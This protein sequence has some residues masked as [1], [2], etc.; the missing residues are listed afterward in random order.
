MV[1]KE[2]REHTGKKRGDYNHRQYVREHPQ[3]LAEEAPRV[4]ARRSRRDVA[5]HTQ[6]SGQAGGRPWAHAGAARPGI[7]NR[8][9]QS[10]LCPASL[11]TIRGCQEVEEGMDV[12]EAAEHTSL[13]LPRLQWG[14][15]GSRNPRGS[16]H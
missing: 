13:C 10:P 2:G 14:H 12:N 7:G 11:L 6:L 15:H 5:G 1:K 8:S 9:L 3:V 4:R 16:L